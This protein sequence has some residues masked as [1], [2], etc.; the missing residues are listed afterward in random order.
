MRSIEFLIGRHK[1]VLLDGGDLP[2]GMSR[3]G[4]TNRLVLPVKGKITLG[5]GDDDR[6]PL[7]LAGRSK[8]VRSGCKP[9]PGE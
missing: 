9:I 2:A 7:R 3:A 1:Q 6:D 5:R 8:E 4:D